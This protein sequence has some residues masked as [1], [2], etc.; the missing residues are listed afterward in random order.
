MINIIDYKDKSLL[1]LG[2]LHGEFSK[3]IGFFKKNQRMISE[4]K[5]HD[6]KPEIKRRHRRKNGHPSSF[7]DSITYYYNTCIVV[8]GDCGFGFNK[9]GYYELILNSLQDLL[10]SQN[11]IL[12]F[13]RGNHDDPKYFNSQ[14]I[15]LNYKNIK[16]VPDYSVLLT[17]HNTTL[18]VGGAISVDR[19]WRQKND[20]TRNRFKLNKDSK[21]ISYW[22]DEKII[23][24]DLNNFITE[25]TDSNIHVDSIIS[26]TL[27]YKI[28]NDIKTTN[29][30]FLSID[31][32][33]LNTEWAKNDPTL[34]DDLISGWDILMNIYKTLLTKNKIQW[35]VCGHYHQIAYD[36]TKDGTSFFILN[37]FDSYFCV[38]RFQETI[39]R[40]QIFEPTLQIEEHDTVKIEEPKNIIDIDDF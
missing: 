13:V 31:E 34:L 11:N 29:P 8:C 12:L 23:N 40:G 20:L 38:D 35:W 1:L 39:Y 21:K 3:L 2:D 25:L 9:I 22:E 6:L 14:D 37:V 36:I 10:E 33:P 27:P 16:F 30:S 7:L 32:S 15:G 4:K 5:S 19:T 26:H 18:C 17:Q 24:I 28:V